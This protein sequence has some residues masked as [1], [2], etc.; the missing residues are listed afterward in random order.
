MKN[1]FQKSLI[2]AAFLA[3]VQ[4][5]AAFAADG[6][7]V[8]LGGTSVFIPNP[9][10]VT[11]PQTDIVYG[12]QKEQNLKLVAP[13]DIKPFPNAKFNLAGVNTVVNPLEKTTLTNT[14]ATNQPMNQTAGAIAINGTEEHTIATS[15]GVTPTGA[16]NMLPNNEFQPLGAAYKVGTQADEE[17]YDFEI[18][19][20]VLK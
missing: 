11:V 17:N 8:I 1:I 16:A 7:W 15:R 19:A 4:G 5:S 12:F 3:I 14:I 2:A 20:P 13:T 6:H 9:V 10:K 18:T